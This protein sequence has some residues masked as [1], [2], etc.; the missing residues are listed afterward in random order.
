MTHRTTFLYLAF[1]W[2]SPSLFSAV[3]PG[4]YIVEFSTEPVAEHMAR[5]G[6]LARTSMRSAEAVSQRSLVRAEQAGARQKLPPDTTV[7]GTVDT[8]DNALIVQSSN[9]SQL[10]SLP[11]VKRVIPVRE[12]HMLLD[13]AVIVDKVVD[14]WNLAG[15]DRAGAGVKIAI[16]DSG[17]DSSHPGFQDSSLPIPDGFPKVNSATDTTYTNNKVIVARSYVNLLP[18]RDP[19]QS[20]RDRVGHGTALA[21]VAA[22]VR[23]TGPLATISG[24]APKAYIGSYKVF[25]TP[26]FNDSSSDAAILKALDDAVTDGMDIINL[27]LGADLAPRFADDPEVQAVERA[28]KAGVIVV[29]AAG[30]S[31][32]DPNTMSSP[33]TAPSAIAVGASHNDRTFAAS[34]QATGLSPIAGVLGDGPVPASPVSAPLA[35]VAGLD[36]NGL[37]CSSLPAGKLSGQIALILRGTC[38]FEAK[39]DNAQAAGA[40]GA[41]V[42]AAATSPDAIS[43]A[44]GAAT[45]P[46]QMVSNSDGVTLK[47][48]VAAQPGLTTTLNFSLTAVPVNPSRLTTFTGAGPNVD[49]SV[50]PDLVA[51]GQDM[52]VATQKFDPNG[53][54][55][56]PSGFIAV[57]GT[58]FASPMVAGAAALLK[59]ARPGLTVDQYRSLL[60]NNADSI[61]AADGSAAGVQQAGGGSLDAAAALRSTATAY[62]TSLAFGT[63]NTATISRSLTISNSGTVS[64]LFTI[65]VVPSQNDSA[66]TVDNNTISLD[67]G[68]SANIAL[69]WNPSG[70][71]AGGHEGYITLSSASTGLVSRVPYWLGVP[72]GT[73]VRITILDSITSARRASLQQDAI[74][75]RMTDSAGL[76]VTG[77]APQVAVTGGLVQDIVSHDMGVPG[78]YGIDVRLAA[79][80][81][82][83]VVTAGSATAT[84]QITGL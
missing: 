6:A 7:L 44:V 46:A 66:P 75:F 61:G 36:G 43:M 69:Q 65:A 82:T 68:A 57:D 51:V 1:A 71:G 80:T 53:D 73:P 74:L 39:L 20:A 67:P 2:I 25:G 54:M 9:P 77:V 60:I 11:G 14:A 47:Q 34:V 10:A 4:H 26:G 49:A 32:P 15:G 58:S 5:R 27:S 29:A 33:A 23:S 56:D 31:G 72:S 17:V 13:R 70:L 52:Y 45:L 41:V 19:D 76:P 50:K 62:P 38:T 37:A 40:V 24:V 8:V 16:I 63:D 35:D 55:Y 78:V 83:F 81:N 79:G 21:M 84:I 18:S 48:A 22:G 42:Y 28:S 64:D 30:N 59:S 3:V 12:I